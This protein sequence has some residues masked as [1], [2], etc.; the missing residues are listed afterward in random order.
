MTAPH[1]PKGQTLPAVP[2]PSLP[3]SSPTPPTH[4]F[5]KPL[6]PA[7]PHQAD[8]QY[9]TTT[10]D[11]TRS[12]SDKGQASNEVEHPRSLCKFFWCSIKLYLLAWFSVIGILVPL[13]EVDKGNIPH[14]SRFIIFMFMCMH[15]IWYVHDDVV[16]TQQKKIDDVISFEG[17]TELHSSL[18]LLV[19]PHLRLF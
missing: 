12:S 1:P 18:M 13:Q 2:T 9:T 8:D 14:N 16:M 7:I 17:L 10:P 5:T 3:P 4:L 11:S 19:Y 6:L 15:G